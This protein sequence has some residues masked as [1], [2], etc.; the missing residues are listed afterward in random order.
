MNVNRIIGNTPM[1]LSF[2]G[3]VILDPFAGIG[4]VGEADAKLG[5]RFVLIEQEAS[6]LSVIRDRAKDWL[7]HEASSILRS[8]AH[9]FK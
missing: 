7:G 1:G 5:R 6:Y 8:I 3:D 9:L 2:K 4:T